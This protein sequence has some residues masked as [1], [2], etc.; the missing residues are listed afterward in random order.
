MSHVKSPRDGHFR[1][2]VKVHSP[3]ILPLFIGVTLVC[4]ADYLEGHCWPHKASPRT[5]KVSHTIDVI[6]HED[7]SPVVYDTLLHDSQE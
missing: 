7:A 1:V 5:E 4:S 3:V 6:L 2:S